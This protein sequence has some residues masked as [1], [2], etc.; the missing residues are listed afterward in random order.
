LATQIHTAISNNAQERF[1]QHFRRF[2]DKTA[3][4]SEKRLRFQLKHKILSL[5]QTTTDALFDSWKS[6]HL[7]NILPSDVNTSVYYDVKKNPLR[8]LKGMLSM[9]KILEDGGHKLFQPLPL[10]T[11]I[12]PK[13]ITIDT[14][15]VIS[16][17]CPDSKTGEL[18]KAVQKN[19]DDV[20]NK[21]LNL[22]HTVFKNKNYR[23]H[24]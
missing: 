14:S 11:N 9:N 7:H 18:L 1:V 4:E 3:P 17:F 6:T 21:L 16:L 15:S 20:W 23:F 22:Q 13:S 10:R 12:I 8:Y 5:E 19:E 24:H 2:V